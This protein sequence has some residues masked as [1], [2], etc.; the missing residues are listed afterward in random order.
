VGVWRASKRAL[1]V[2]HIPDSELEESVREQVE[3]TTRRKIAA[4]DSSRFPSPSERASILPLQIVCWFCISEGKQNLAFYEGQIEGSQQ[5]AGGYCYWCYFCGNGSTLY[6]D[7]FVRYTT[8]VAATARGENRFGELVGRAR[9]NEEGK[10]RCAICGAAAMVEMAEDG[11]EDLCESCAV[12]EYLNDV[13][14]EGETKPGELEDITQTANAIALKYNAKRSGTIFA[15]NRPAPALTEHPAVSVAGRESARGQ[16]TPK[17]TLR[18]L[19]GHSLRLLWRGLDVSSDFIANKLIAGAK[20]FESIW[21]GIDEILGEFML[22]VLL[23]SFVVGLVWLVKWLWVHL[24][25]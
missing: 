20:I 10:P 24:P 2:A 15:Y 9:A 11:Y 3:E 21:S 16:G 12:T 14:A 5:Q 25:V 6:A 4:L 19:A 8:D 17:R 22:V 13:W 18:F 1:G 7:D 23:V